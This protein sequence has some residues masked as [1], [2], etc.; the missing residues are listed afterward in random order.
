M[1]F[2]L[3]KVAQNLADLS[4]EIC[5]FGRSLTNEDNKKKIMKFV[6][7]IEEAETDIDAEELID[8]CER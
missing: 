7:I 5:D 3:G 6:T 2:F 8:F 1:A 4:S